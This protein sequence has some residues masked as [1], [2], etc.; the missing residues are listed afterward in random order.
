MLETAFCIQTQQVTAG[1]A[2]ELESTDRRVG[3]NLQVGALR[4]QGH[5]KEFGNILNV[6]K[7]LGRKRGRE[8]LRRGSA[9]SYRRKNLVGCKEY[10]I[11]LGS[12]VGRVE[13]VDLGRE[14]SRF[15]DVIEGDLAADQGLV[16]AIQLAL[17]EDKEKEEAR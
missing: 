11:Q 7:A 10:Q 13:D 14:L 1:S 4:D 8:A 6:Q 17:L 12:C 15:T 2:K 3:E 5:V 16:G 9:D